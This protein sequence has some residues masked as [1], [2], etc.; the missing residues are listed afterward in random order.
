MAIV[1]RSPLEYPE[2]VKSGADGPP[3]LSVEFANS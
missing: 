3:N 1:P 2:E